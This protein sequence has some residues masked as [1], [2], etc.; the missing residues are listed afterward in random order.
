MFNGLDLHKKLKD[1]GLSE[2]EVQQLFPGLAKT[3]DDVQKGIE[4][5]Y[6][7]KFPKGEYLIA[8]TDANKQYLADL[9]KLNQ[10]R[11]KNSQDLVIELTKLI[12]HS[13]QTS[14]S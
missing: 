12:K 4:A 2:A 6:Q 14:C 1:A 7:K 5:E 10:Q 9:N 3:L 13:F 8:D 11:I